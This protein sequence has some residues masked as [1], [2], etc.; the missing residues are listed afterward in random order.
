MYSKNKLKEIKPHIEIWPTISSKKFDVIFNR[1]RIGLS[2]LTH[3][4]LL[5]AKEEPT[6]SHC[7]SSVLVIRHL[8]TVLAY[9]I[10]KDSTFIPHHLL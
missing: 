7:H 5:L 1:L 8:L 9:V 4:H 10:C 2:R 3:R 6:C